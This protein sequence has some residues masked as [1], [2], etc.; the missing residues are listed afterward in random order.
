ME[1]SFTVG[2][3][4]I[5]VWCCHTKNSLEDEISAGEIEGKIRYFSV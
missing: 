5:R 1:D 4:M 3:F 2:K